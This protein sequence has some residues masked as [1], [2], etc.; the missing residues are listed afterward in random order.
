MAIL[1]LVPTI[2]AAIQR[3]LLPGQGKH[4]WILVINVINCTPFPPGGQVDS[5]TS[6]SSVPESSADSGGCERRKENLSRHTPAVG[7]LPVK[8]KHISNGKSSGKKRPLAVKN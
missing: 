8:R 5:S 6:K 2:R 1:S 4:K 3:H 7:K